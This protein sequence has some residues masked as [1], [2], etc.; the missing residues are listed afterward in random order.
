MQAEPCSDIAVGPHSYRLDCVGAA[1]WSERCVRV[2]RRYVEGRAATRVDRR[3][4]AVGW[5]FLARFDHHGGIGRSAGF[6]CT[7]H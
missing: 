4:G 5:G 2:G 6:Q 7:N 3:R 1:R